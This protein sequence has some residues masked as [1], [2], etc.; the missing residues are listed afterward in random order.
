MISKYTFLLPAY[1]AKYFE[2]V[3]LSIKNQNYKDF[4]LIVS[5][6]C[7]P[8]DIKSIYDRIVGDDSRFVYRRNDV[9]MGGKSLVSHWNLLVDLCNTEFFIMASD[10]DIYEPIFLD[11]IDKLSSDFRG[12]PS[13]AL[14]EV[15]D[16]AQNHTFNDHYL[17]LDFDLSK[18]LF[19]ATGNILHTIPK[20]LLDRME[21]NQ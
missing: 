2:K 21:E 11:E 10:D 5:D 8:A 19:L 17:D 1:K 9:N 20:P 15:L 4:N 3:L 7:S 18:V 6:D 14:L 13:S 16:P 12:D